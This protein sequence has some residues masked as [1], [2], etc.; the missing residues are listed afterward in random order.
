MKTGIISL[1]VIVTFI[2]IPSCKQS[3]NKESGGHKNKF[4]QVLKHYELEPQKQLAARFLIENMDA[5]YSYESSYHDSFLADIDSLYRNYPDKHSNFY[6]E[7]Y[8]ILSKKY[9]APKSV[10]H[11]SLDI[12]NIAADFLIR[13]IDNAF[14]M[15][16][17]NWKEIYGFEHFCNYVLP[18]RIGNEPVSDWPSSYISEYG[19]KTL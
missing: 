18:Y 13:H 9:K 5:H 11:K 6:R 17:S 1:I 12:E 14:Q 16:Q 8:D 7:A 3:F 19:E 4:E 2:S 15:W 10:Y